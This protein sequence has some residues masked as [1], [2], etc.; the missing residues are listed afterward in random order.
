MKVALVEYNDYH[1]EV[2]PSLVHLL[3]RLGIRPDVYMRRKAIARNAFEYAG[4][5]RWH[6]HDLDGLG[7]KVLGT[8]RRFR[9]YDLAI[10]ASIEPK[11]RLRAAASLQMPTAAVVHNAELLLED[12]DYRTF[13]ADAKRAPLVLGRH[14]RSHLKERGITASW[15]PFVY[16]GLVPRPIRRRGPVTFAVPGNL[17]YGRRNYPALLDALAEVRQ[18]DDDVRVRVI[19]RSGTPDGYRFRTE[20]R[21]RNLAEI[22]AFDPQP[23]HGLY[24][25]ALLECDFLLP[26][27]DRSS[28]QFEHYYDVKVASAM[29]MAVALGVPLVAEHELTRT[30]GVDNATIMYGPGGLAEAIRSAVHLS[31]N[32]R[33]V[34]IENLATVRATLLNDGAASLGAL[35]ASITNSRPAALA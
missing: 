18:H 4:E 15:A 10:V 28:P 25:R 9:T 26:L 27:V 21:E 17:E 7:A 20:L 1:D 32:E 12:P 30:Y 31:V 16:F 34:L 33:D 2:L 11:S 29:Y 19:G 24:L 22:V 13:F 6:R 35:I 14:I 3:N 5:L 23:T 8:P